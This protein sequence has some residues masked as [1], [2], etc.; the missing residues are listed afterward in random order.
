MSPL[1]VADAPPPV[2]PEPGWTPC[3][4]LPAADA[5]RSFVSGGTTGRRLRVAY[6]R[7]D[8]DQHLVGRVWFGPETEGPPGHAHGGAVAAALDEA[9]GSAAWAAG[10]P[11]VV[12]RLTVDFRLMVPLGIDATFDAWVESVDGRKIRTRAR[13]VGADDQVLAEGHAICVTLATEHIEKLRAARA[14]R[15]SH[16]R[17]HDPGHHRKSQA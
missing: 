7:R 15:S 12:A 16:G 17:G 5:D 13:L 1:P 8:A 6:F 3:Q 9:L 10:H 14:R 4:P 2:L 11:V